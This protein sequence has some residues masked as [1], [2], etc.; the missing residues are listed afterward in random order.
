MRCGF[1]FLYSVHAQDL[2]AFKAGKK[3]AAAAIQAV[4]DS[5]LG[6]IPVAF[7]IRNSCQFNTTGC[8]ILDF[9]NVG[10]KNK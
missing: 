6:D 3:D 9:G 8:N 4:V 2:S 1:C 10:S 7:V 5:G